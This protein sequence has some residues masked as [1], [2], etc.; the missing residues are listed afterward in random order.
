M[1]KYYTNRSFYES[2][3]WLVILVLPVG[4]LL[5]LVWCQKPGLVKKGIETFTSEKRCMFLRYNP[6]DQ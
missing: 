1:E 4:I 2:I 3:G 5:F 6:Q